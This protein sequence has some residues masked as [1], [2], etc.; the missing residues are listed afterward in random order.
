VKAVAAVT[1]VIK[2]K[3][4]PYLIMVEP[5]AQQTSPGGEPP[6]IRARLRP[7]G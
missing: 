7:P 1:G 5:M 4:N 3:S 2:D 6:T